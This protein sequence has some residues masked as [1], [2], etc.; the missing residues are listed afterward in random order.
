[1]YI[2]AENISKRYDTGWIIKDFNLELKSGSKLAVMGPNGS[3]KS[4]LISMLASYLSPSKGDIVYRLNNESIERDKL[5]Q[6]LS[7]CT[8]YGEL[9]E[10]LTAL[11]IFKHYKIFKPYIIKDPKT[12]IELSDLTKHRNKAIRD[13]SSGM[14]Q[15]LKLALA[16]LMDVPFLVL[17]EPSSFLDNDRKKW[18]HNLLQEFCSSKT[19]IM[20]SNDESDFQLCTEKIVLE[21]I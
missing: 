6:Y 11:E 20:A 19:M 12:F 10:E 8:A 21:A 2:S 18:F 16:I 3:G 5:Y 7:I 17:D 4:T 9:D 14:K 15:R 13:Y 1:M